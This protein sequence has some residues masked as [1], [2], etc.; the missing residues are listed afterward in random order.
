M[1]WTVVPFGRYEGKTLPE[2]I[3]RDLDWFF[4]AL[5]KLYGR[6]AYEAKELARKVRS[7]K[8]PKSK[9]GKLEV[10][11]RYEFGG[12]FCGFSFVEADNPNYTR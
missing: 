7:I 4:W 5:P 6:L 1:R 11:Y 3:I 8:I 12:R 2:I 9:K 10:E